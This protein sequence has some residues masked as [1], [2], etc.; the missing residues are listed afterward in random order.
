MLV[1]ANIFQ[2]LITVFAHVILFFHNHVGLSWGWSIILLTICVRL[3]LVPLSVKQFRSMRRLQQHQPEMKAIQAKYKEDKERQQQEMMKFYKENNVNPFSSCLPMLF[4]LPVFI[5]LFY[6]LRKNLRSDICPTI[7]KTLQ[8]KYAQTYAAAHHIAATSATAVHAAAGQ[9]FACGPVKGA[10]FL[11]INDITNNAKGVTLI[12]LLILYVGTQVVSTQ[13]MAAPTMD[14]SQQRMMML[15]PLLF[16]LFIIRFP[17]G[18][19]VY[20]ITTNAWTM[21]Q[22]F[23]LKTIIGGPSPLPVGNVSVAEEEIKE[24]EHSAASRLRGALGRPSAKSSPP[25][26]TGRNGNRAAGGPPPP[27][28]RKKKKRSGRRR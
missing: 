25:P 8:A 12:V 19:I 15:M 14:K 24:A 4:Q 11:F 7:Q 18:L 26:T 20:W 2:P 9:T 6:M 27:S 28:P 21:F 23:T 1:S 22:Q 17:A 16:V 3:V 5:S 13:I 10:G